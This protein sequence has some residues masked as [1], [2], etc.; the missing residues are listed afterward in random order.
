[1]EMVDIL[2]HVHPDLS[3]ARRE[4]LEEELRGYPGMLSV[5]F[6]REHPHL[7][8]V[9]YDPNAISSAAILNLVGERGVQASR[10]GL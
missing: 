8:V 9:E 1:M 2:I 3:A 4:T 6:S 5:H 7:L 10:I